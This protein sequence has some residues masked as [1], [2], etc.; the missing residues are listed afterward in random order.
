MIPAN[1]FMDAA[2]QVA[3]VRIELYRNSREKR[4]GVLGV[5][6]ESFLI[7]AVKAFLFTAKGAKFSAKIAKNGLQN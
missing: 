6:C 1:L 7:F 3:M 2:F 4:V 5:L